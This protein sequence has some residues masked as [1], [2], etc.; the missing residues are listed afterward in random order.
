MTLSKMWLKMDR[1]VE[2]RF[3]PYLIKCIQGNIF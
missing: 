1:S 3:L 2:D